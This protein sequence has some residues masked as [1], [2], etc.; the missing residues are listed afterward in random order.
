MLDRRFLPVLIWCAA[1]TLA[2]AWPTF[3]PPVTPRGVAFRD[4]TVGIEMFDMTGDTYAAILDAVGQGRLVSSNLRDGF[5]AFT[6][7]LLSKAH[8]AARIKVANE[9]VARYVAAEQS[10][11]RAPL[12]GIWAVLALLVPAAVL[13]G[14]ALWRKPQPLTAPPV[15]P[16]RM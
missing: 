9:V 13:A 15:K 11:K 5:K 3:A 4:D 7:P 10:A 8:L 14:N 12:L 16:E 1:V 6:P 2:M